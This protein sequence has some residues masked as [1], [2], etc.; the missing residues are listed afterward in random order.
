MGAVSWLTV[1]LL[2]SVPLGFAWGLLVLWGARRGW[3]CR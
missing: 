3:W 2:A 1:A